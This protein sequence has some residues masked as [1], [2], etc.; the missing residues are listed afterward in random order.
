P[1]PEAPGGDHTAPGGVRAGRRLGARPV[2]R[3]G[4]DAAGGE[5]PRA[6]GDRCRNREGLLRTGS[7]A[8]G[9]GR[10]ATLAAEGCQDGRGGFVRGVRTMALLT[11]KAAA[12]RLGCSP[13]LVYLLCSERKLAHFRLGGTIRLEES[14]LDAFL[15]GCKVEANSLHE[16]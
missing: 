7:P 8:A 1:Q 13:A 12:A 14:D 15:A 11:V 9:A 2:R 5:G 16:D 3:V 6:F 10:V 4:Y